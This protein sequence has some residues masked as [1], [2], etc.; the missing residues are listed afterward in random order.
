MKRLFF[1]AVVLSSA[2]LFGQKNASVSFE[3]WISLKAV[4]GPIISPDGKIIVYNMSSTDWA[5]NTYD[6]ELWMAKDGE[7]PLQLTR[8]NKNSTGNAAFTPDGKY[9]SFIADRGDKRQIYIISVAGGEAIQVTK[10]EDGINSYAWHPDGTRI[11]YSKTQPKSKKDK[12][13]E[14]RFGAFGVEGEEYQLTHLWLLNFS[15]DSV[16]LAGQ[17]PCYSSKDTSKTNKNPD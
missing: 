5:N 12:T 13:K 10:D 4:S 9:V 3:K 16:F 11:V 15:Y 1:M 8:T 7:A 17:L 2:A 6:N 14:E